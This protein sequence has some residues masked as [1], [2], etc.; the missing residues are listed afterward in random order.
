[1]VVAVDESQILVHIDDLLVILIDLLL[2]IITGV[3][4]LELLQLLSQLL[5]IFLKSINLGFTS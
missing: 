2:F 3:I 4:D 1:M 5:I